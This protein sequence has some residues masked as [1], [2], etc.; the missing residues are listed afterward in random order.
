MA[1]HPP[2]ATGAQGQIPAVPGYK[3]VGRLGAGGMG[4][5]YKAMQLSMN[6][7]VALKI[8][9]PRYARDA[10]FLER[11]RREINTMAKLSHPNIVTAIDTGEAGGAPYYVMEFV[12]G[13]T[14]TDLVKKGGPLT[15]ARTLEFGVQVARALAHAGR[16][17]LIHRDIKPDN[18]MVTD[19]G[20][21]KLCDLGIAKSLE[22]SAD[23]SLTTDGIA[24]GT[25]SYLSPE[26]AQGL[27]ADERSDIYSLG[28]TLYYAS[29]GKAPFG[30]PTA[31]AILRQHITVTPPS[32]EQ[33]N[34][35][36]S[37]PFCS[38]IMRMLAKEAKDR[39][40]GAHD[41]AHEMERLL[42]RGGTG[43][44][45][46]P[47]RRSRFAPEAPSAQA[48]R[49][50][51]PALITATILLVGAFA[52]LIYVSKFQKPK[53]V[54]KPPPTVKPP[55]N[56]TPNPNPNPIPSPD[57]PRIFLQQE[58][59]RLEAAM[60]S[61][62]RDAETSDQLRNWF[63]VLGGLAGEEKQLS[64]EF[65]KRAKALVKSIVPPEAFAEIDRAAL[66]PAEWQ[67][68]QEQAREWAERLDYLAWIGSQQARLVDEPMQRV[69]EAQGKAMKILAHSGTFV[70]SVNFYPAEARLVR[71]AKEGTVLVDGGRGQGRLASWTS[72]DL[73]MPVGI[74]GLEAGAWEIEV[75]KG[76][77]TVKAKLEKEKIRTGR[78]VNVW[79]DINKG[80]VYVS[81]D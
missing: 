65:L 22:E 31:A 18:I 49:F 74:V 68:L 78:R 26:Q 70:L 30:G 3:I 16:H 7:P 24:I 73:Q 71:L 48:V 72:E 47:A 46:A 39:H 9:Y 15:E 29:T 32:P 77:K 76:G 58:W 28:V 23:S 67:G 1:Q 66:A 12:D 69:N 45:M 79:G 13:H 81:Y 5:V 59:V 35:R 11:F 2:P 10:E 34:P 19:E 57:D 64:E 8:L 60:K 36:L 41:L 37:K 63:D 52:V 27:P 61:R 75:G 21:A 50:I 40:Q 55:D 17:K 43:G 4:V 25:P 20:V 38:M 33:H 44:P 53:V 42:K 6:R 56:P 80:T 51:K 14:V 62:T 54:I